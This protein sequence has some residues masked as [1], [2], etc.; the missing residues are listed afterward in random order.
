MIKAFEGKVMVPTVDSDG[1]MMLGALIMT[2]EQARQFAQE[3]LV[4]AA[5]AAVQRREET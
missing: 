1:R 2:P 5:E 4:A 3:I